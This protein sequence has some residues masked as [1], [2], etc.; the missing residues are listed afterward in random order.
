MGRALWM[1]SV[2]LNGLPC[3]VWT[4]D[5]ERLVQRVANRVLEGCGIPETD[6]PSHGN[7]IYIL[8]RQCSDAE[9]RRVVEKYLRA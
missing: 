4:P 2:S 8:R 1:V 7:V 6:T 5:Q 9:R 3:S